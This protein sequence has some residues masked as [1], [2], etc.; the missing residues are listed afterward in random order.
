MP[1]DQRVSIFGLR[2][3]EDKL[4]T[5]KTFMSYYLGTFDMGKFE[6]DSTG[7]MYIAC[8]ARNCNSHFTFLMFLFERTEVLE[9]EVFGTQFQ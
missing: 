3:E 6:A 4:A 5:M 7:S 2:V 8:R 9:L 1:S